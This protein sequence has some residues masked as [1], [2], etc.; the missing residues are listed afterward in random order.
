[1]NCLVCHAALPT[2]PHAGRPRKY[3]EDHKLSRRAH[4]C[5]ETC[6]FY[7]RD[8]ARER[9]MCALY[10]SGLTLAAIGERYGITRERV[11]Q[12]IA[13]H[14]LS[15]KSGGAS[16][17]AKQRR[18]EAQARRDARALKKWGC[19]FAQYQMLRG[20]PRKDGSYSKGPTGA[21]KRQAQSARDRGIAW[22]LTLWQWWQIWDASAKWNER[23]RGQGYVMA[24]KADEGPYSVDNVYI[25]TAIAHSSEA[26]KKKKSNLPCG[27]SLKNGRYIANRMLRG[28]KLYLG[29][30]PTPSEAHQA[31]LLAGAA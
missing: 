20:M 22:H 7:H 25:T 8:P 3:C 12:L 11:R 15:A 30:F 19:S 2:H 5:D 21:F 1:M 14:G 6:R 26:P 10:R 18:A 27:V 28:Q 23:G 24:R 4:V 16:K 17:R 9:D 13:R 29:T 31:Y